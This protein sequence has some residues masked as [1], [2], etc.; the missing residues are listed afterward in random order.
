[1]DGHWHADPDSRQFPSLAP[2]SHVSRLKTLCLLRPCQVVVLRL[3][4]WCLHIPFKTLPSDRF[5]WLVCIRLLRFCS[6]SWVWSALNNKQHRRATNN[7][8][9]NNSNNNNNIIYWIDL[10]TENICDDVFASEILGCTAIFSRYFDWS[11][12][13]EFRYKNSRSLLRRIILGYKPC[14]Y[15]HVTSR[16]HQT[17]VQPR[18]ISTVTHSLSRNTY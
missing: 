3:F 14:E 17:T 15:M 13:P 8:N 18:F 16:N 1:M 10:K 2:S 7:S 4:K 12:L 11:S 5:C 9:S 6:I